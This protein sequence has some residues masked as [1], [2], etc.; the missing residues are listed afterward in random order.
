MSGWSVG[1][2]RPTRALPAALALMGS[3]SLSSVGALGAL[4]GCSDDGGQPRCVTVDP[5]CTPRYEPTFANV[6]ANTLRDSCGSQSGVCHSAAGRRGG[7]SMESASVAFAEL[8]DATTGRVVPGD[9]SC[10]EMIVRLH[11]NG[12]GYLMPPGAQLPAP[13]RCAIERWIAAGAMPSSV[14]PVP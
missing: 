9:P 14:G 2:V 13:E 12:E 1:A 5:A 8:T 4:G 7:L 11:G 10:S 6:Y 3:L